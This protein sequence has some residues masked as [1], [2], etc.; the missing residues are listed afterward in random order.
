MKTKTEPD[1]KTA[2]LSIDA[3]A[4]MLK[5]DRRT[6]GEALR[7]AHEI[8]Y[9]E[10]HDM[11]G[12]RGCARYLIKDACSALEVYRVRQAPPDLRA[13]C[14]RLYA[15]YERARALPCPRCGVPHDDPASM[16]IL[17]LH[18]KRDTPEIEAWYLAHGFPYD[19]PEAGP[20]FPN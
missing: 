14:P 9:L 3:C 2:P 16:P 19:Y 13:G 10:P 17:P 1:L 5:T 18:G 11:K 15:D 12:T 4:R 20:N 8:D 7:Q 6:L